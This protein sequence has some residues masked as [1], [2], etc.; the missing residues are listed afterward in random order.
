MFHS[1]LIYSRLARKTKQRKYLKR[2]KQMV[3]KMSHVTKTRGGNNLHRYLLMK[4][5]AMAAS[6]KE[7]IP[8]VKREYDNAIACCARSGYVHDTA[9]GYELAAEYFLSVQE[10][11]RQTHPGSAASAKK[12]SSNKKQQT[13]KDRAKA[14]S[15]QCITN[16]IIKDYLSN[17]V[18]LYDEWGAKAK[19]G[20]MLSKY[21][22]K[23]PELASLVEDSSKGKKTK[24]HT[25]EARLCVSAAHKMFDKI[26]LDVL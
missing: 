16:D 2:A 6:G 7:K 25:A 18:S 22:T 3:S 23:F 14:S 12:P 9:L 19:V 20:R 8:T 17:S 21:L 24:G 10:Q 5:D 4:A 1:S 26:N 15:P 13:N 11:Q